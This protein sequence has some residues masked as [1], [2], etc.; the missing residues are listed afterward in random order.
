ML[1]IIVPCRPLTGKLKL[2][3]N[4]SRFGP[5]FQFF[6][7]FS[8]AHVSAALGWRFDCCSQR[9]WAWLFMRK[10]QT[11]CH[12]VYSK[13]LVVLETDVKADSYHASGCHCFPHRGFYACTR[14]YINLVTCKFSNLRDLSHT[15]AKLLKISIQC[16]ADVDN[17]NGD[18]AN[19]KPERTE[20]QNYWLVNYL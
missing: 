19:K 14:P 1:H 11:I 13:G 3:V 12:R 6:R 15:V 10:V 4:C 9:G 16:T 5:G 20:L 8:C 7:S 17:A 2:L 18:N